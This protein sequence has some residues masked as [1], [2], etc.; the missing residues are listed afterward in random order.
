MLILC[1]QALLW[2]GAASAGNVIGG[3]GKSRVT[4]I[5]IDTAKEAEE[6]RRAHEHIL[7]DSPFNDKP[8]ELRD[9]DPEPCAKPEQDYVWREEPT[10]D[11]GQA[12][13]SYC[14][15]T[16]CGKRLYTA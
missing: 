6:W 2:L 14:L 13:P 11:V 8:E 12:A 4:E 9:D 7:N 5:I 15:S 16:D 10:I 3:R 1:A